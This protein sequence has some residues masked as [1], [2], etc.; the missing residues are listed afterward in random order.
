MISLIFVVTEH[1]LNTVDR[2]IWK[3]WTRRKLSPPSENI[4][5]RTGTFYDRYEALEVE[6]QTTGEVSPSGM[7]RP[8]KPTS[9]VPHIKTSSVLRKRRVIVIR[10]SL[11]QGSDIS[12]RLVLTRQAQRVRVTGVTSGCC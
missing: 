11:L 1:F 6:N 3:W 10:H 8:P 4:T 9:S 12:A 5:S 2:D 7:E